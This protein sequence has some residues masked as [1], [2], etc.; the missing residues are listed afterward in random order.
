MAVSLGELSVQLTAQTA[1]FKRRLDSAESRLDKF[2]NKADSSTRRSGSSFKRLGKAIGGV[3]VQLTTLAGV[4]ATIGLAKLARGSLEAAGSFEQLRV[5]LQVFL[6]T[7]EKANDAFNRFV[8]IAAKTPFTV[9]GVIQAAATLAVVTGDN[10]D[11]LEKLV[12]Q[13][14]NVAAVA[15]IDIPEA[16][17]NM[18]R[19]LTTG[20]ASAELLRDRGITGLIQ[21]MTGVP[22]ATK[23]STGALGNLARAF[24]FVFGATGRYGDAAA[25]LS[26]TLEGK[27]SNIGDAAMRMRASLGEALAPAVIDAAET[28]IIPFFT[29]LRETIEAN[30][31][32]MQAY[33]AR[34]IPK[35]I[36]AFR[37]IVRI[38]AGLVRGLGF[39][40][41]AWDGLRIVGAL[42]Q[43]QFVAW[44]ELFK[45][46]GRSVFLLVRVILEGSKALFFAT[47]FQFEKAR[48]AINNTRDA[49]DDYTGKVRTSFQAITDAKDVM[50]EL[51]VEAATSEKFTDGLA[52]GLDTL[53]LVANDVATNM[54][55]A[56]DAIEEAGNKAD[57]AAPKFEK[58]PLPG[59]TPAG[60]IRGGA[61]GETRGLAT[62]TERVDLFEEESDRRAIENIKKGLEDPKTKEATT[63][64]GEQLG[65]TV[66][67]GIKDALTA[68]A[69]GD[70]QNFAETLGSLSENFLD[71]AF[72][73][74][75]GN[76]EEGLGK[77]FDELEGRMPGL[78]AAVSGAL[79]IGLALVSGALRKTTASVT[80]AAIESAVTSTQAVRG[81]VA[82]PTQIAIGEVATGIEDAFRPSLRL[83]EARNQLLTE[84]LSTTRANSGSSAF[85]GAVGTESELGETSAS[86]A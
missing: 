5:R 37:D 18:A 57:E 8:E 78:G 50:A 2:E 27:F 86:L 56:G 4:I 31:E 44:I 46:I 29:K 12:F 1:E 71:L 39:L 33:S 59:S 43:L 32:R 76:M 52:S 51:A 19:A 7:Q 23:L 45:T 66:Q 83:D 65:G 40:I 20:L 79:A 49:W 28:I 42:V 62:L 36:G 84:L 82:G 61:L 11:A 72:E 14:A 47:N 22:D 63:T 53:A 77:L 3:T 67:S 48:E 58:I 80:D 74:V 15:S 38:G 64:F 21:K 69:S 16:A 30:S 68:L 10:V 24:D 17:S 55:K 34:V 35:L 26:D 41:D 73:R 60:E 70:L 13:A 75:L 81:V 54:G 25:A 9:E 85:T 6:G